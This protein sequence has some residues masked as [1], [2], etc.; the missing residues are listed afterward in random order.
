MKGITFSQA[1][2][3]IMKAVRETLAK[4]G[5][6]FEADF[7]SVLTGEEEALYSLV[8]VNLLG[9]N[10]SDFF[11]GNVWGNCLLFFFFFYFFS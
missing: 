3:A 4:S 2:E 8:A 7:D 6:Y 11:K 1:A 9:Q 10:S 5:F